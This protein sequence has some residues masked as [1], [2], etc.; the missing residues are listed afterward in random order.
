L[1]L[2]NFLVNAGRNNSGRITVFTKGT[3]HKKI[4]KKL[5]LRTP[6]LEG[7]VESIEYDAY[8]TV[9]VAPVFIQKFKSPFYTLALED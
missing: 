4:F 9:S 8:R 7:I 2:K 3:G 1:S 6:F 5:I